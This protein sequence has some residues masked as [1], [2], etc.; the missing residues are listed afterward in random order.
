[1]KRV[2]GI[3]NILFIILLIPAECFANKVDIAQEIIRLSKDVNKF[4]GKLLEMEYEERS[5]DKLKDKY[6][7]I[8]VDIRALLIQNKVRRLNDASISI[9]KTTLNK[10]IQYKKKHKENWGK[11]LLPKDNSKKISAL[12]IY[13]DNL[14]MYHRK[15]F[16]RLL[17]AMLA[18]EVRMPGKHSKMKYKKSLVKRRKS[19]RK[20]LATPGAYKDSVEEFDP[21]RD[22]AYGEDF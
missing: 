21:S 8:E 9:S 22:N 4:Y 12:N 17:T 3:V 19:V 13:K 11:Y 10:W 18:E 2:I 6:I 14:I 20:K 7:D 5:Y 1:M 16:N 15:R